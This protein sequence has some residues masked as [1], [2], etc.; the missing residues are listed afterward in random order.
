MQNEMGSL[1]ERVMK[2]FELL[3]K[4]HNFEDSFLNDNIFISYDLKT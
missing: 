3:I 2:I 4:L 1:A